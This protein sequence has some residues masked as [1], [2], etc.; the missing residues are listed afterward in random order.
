[1]QKICDLARQMPPSD[2]IWIS[3]QNQLFSQG[4]SAEI[5]ARGGRYHKP[6]ES[7]LGPKL[8]FKAPVVDKIR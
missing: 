7:I 2:F 8:G 3:D 6:P 4:I 1:M 5:W